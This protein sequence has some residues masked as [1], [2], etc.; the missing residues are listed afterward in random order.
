MFTI[1][2]VTIVAFILM[3]IGGIG[4]IVTFKSVFQTED[5]TI[6]NEVI[7]N[8]QITSIDFETDN[9]E[10][11]VKQALDEAITLEFKHN[12][13]QDELVTKQD[14]EKLLIKTIEKQKPVVAFGI[15][16]PST[17]LTVYLPETVNHS[18]FIS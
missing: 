2:R 18:L 17:K 12:E 3:F 14:G 9:I 11:E 5:L 13:F 8:D 16:L 6:K 10:V 15:P 4:S 1:K 7:D